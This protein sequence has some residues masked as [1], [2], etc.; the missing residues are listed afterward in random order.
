MVLP[1]GPPKEVQCLNP[2]RAVAGSEAWWRFRRGG[3][4]ARW[5]ADVVMGGLSFVV[6]ARQPTPSSTS[7]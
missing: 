7:G 2:N 1:A 4:P 6:A 5:Q 3:R